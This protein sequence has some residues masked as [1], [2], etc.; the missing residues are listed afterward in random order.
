MANKSY[1]TNSNDDPDQLDF[2]A[3]DEL[4]LRI[5]N[6]PGEPPI[7]PEPPPPEPPPG[8]PPP[9]P[10]PPPPP[11][12]PRPQPT[13]DGRFKFRVFT[14]TPGQD[15]KLGLGD[16][17]DYR[18]EFWVDWGDGSAPSPIGSYDDDN[19]VHVYADVGSYVIEMW[20]HCEYFGTLYPW[21]MMI[22]DLISFEGDMGFKHIYFYVCQNLETLCPF[23]TMESLEDLEYV[24]ESISPGYLLP[25]PTIPEDIFAGCPNVTSCLRAFGYNVGLLGS[26]IPEDLFRY[27]TKITTFN[28]VFE[29]CTT[30]DTV[31]AGIFRYN[32]EVT[33]FGRAFYYDYNFT[34]IPADL[35]RYNTK[36]VDFS[37]TFNNNGITS[38][39]SGLFDYNTEA[40]Y[41]SAT[42]YTCQVL[43]IVPS[44]LFTN[45]RKAYYFGATF[46]SCS[47][48]H[49]NAGI[50]GSAGMDADSM[51]LFFGT[52]AYAGS[53]IPW[54]PA[55]YPGT[56]PALWLNVYPHGS[57]G[58]NCFFGLYYNAVDNYG[59]IPQSWR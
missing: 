7:P 18:Q 52:F 32:T 25:F 17:E 41:F 53:S 23:G 21:G 1:I 27:N 56:A 14:Q 58:Y 51:V 11:G 57:S 33:T 36:V 16:S 19:R 46:A 43:D 44:G 38:I 24:F 29:R 40:L 30:L 2:Y 22:K 35:F 55:G 10:P 54:P 37:D 48:M 28:G 45:C 4:V 42:F 49:Q 5:T 39:P 20:G 34:T 6:P 13:I 31:P 50:M 47:I 8:P 9:G 12:P 26:D 15:F 59:D 3:A